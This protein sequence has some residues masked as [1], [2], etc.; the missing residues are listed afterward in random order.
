MKRALLNFLTGLS[1]LLFVAVAGCAIRDR[2]RWDMV[3][4]RSSTVEWLFWFRNGS[5]TVARAAG[6][7]AAG[8]PASR[9]GWE[10]E[11]EQVQ[12]SSSW[13]EFSYDGPGKAGWRSRGFVWVEFPYW[14]GALAFA[15]VPGLWLARRSLRVRRR[16]GFCPR[17]GYDLRATPGRCPECGREP[18]QRRKNT[19]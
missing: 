12:N 8:V 3:S 4:H 11:V 16:T 19:F 1:L 9:A 18:G 7:S 5:L 10:W 6:D 14:F 2:F 13:G 15:V 17:C